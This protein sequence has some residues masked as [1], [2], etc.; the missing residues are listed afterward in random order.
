MHILRTSGYDGEIIAVN[1]RTPH[2]EGASSA[3]TL[4]DARPGPIDH[5]LVLTPATT[6]SD[7]VRACVDRQVGAVTLLSS[8]VGEPVHTDPAVHLKNLIGD[9][10]LRVL[11]PN[12]LGVLN[13]HT[14]LVASPA[15]AFMSGPLHAGGISIVSQSGAVGAYLVGLLA[16]VN[17][18]V[19]YFAS[20]GNEF[21]IQLG[22]VVRHFT[23]DDHTHSIALYLEGLRDVGTFIDS[24]A[25]AR[26]R[27]KDVIVIKAGGTETGAAAVRSHTAAMAGDDA[28][29]DAVFQRL[30]AYRVRSVGE[31]VEVLRACANRPP[32]GDR[33]RR[34]GVM[35]TSGG[36]G[37]LATEAL[38]HEGFEIPEV[39]PATQDHLRSVLPMCT[40]GRPIDLGGTVPRDPAEFLDLLQRTVDD[41]ALDSLVVVVSNMP[42]SPLAWSAIRATLVDLIGSRPVPI[43]VVGAVSDADS[44]M[45]RGLG[46][47]TASDPAAAAGEL[48]VLDRLATLR[49]S[50]GTVAHPPTPTPASR[51]VA[52]A[53]L[54]AMEMLSEHGIRF[55]EQV[56]LDPVPGHAPS[57]LG[58]I[59]LPAAVKLLQPGVLHKAA[60]GNVVTGVRDRAEIDALVRDFRGKAEGDGHILVQAMVDHVL[61]EVIVSIR[62]D[63]TFGPV[64]M[65]GSGGRHVELLKDRVLLLQPI[66]SDDVAGALA[67]LTFLGDLGHI[68]DRVNRKITEVVLAIQAVLD[69]EPR[70]QEVEINPVILRSEAPMAVAVDA[71]V[72]IAERAENPADENVSTCTPA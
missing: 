17:L 55:P 28:T 31:A 38:I 69:H 37:I 6:V 47:V 71:V 1:P 67:R 24:L 15:S 34:V 61:D 26:R 11:G 30:G 21:D 29:Y 41:L 51:V 14:R 43:V 5:A 2:F 25:E 8:G 58:K 70:V 65:I 42:R 45:F 4:A 64:V 63:P 62:R 66:S 18:G 56:V 39:P 23:N 48:T 44:A 7:V 46:A 68:A 33:I 32:G 10:G 35:T 60:A 52:M 22:E 36:L 9:S 16:Q 72:L 57:G 12:C 27:G 50:S 54:A 13:A 3:A 49:A 53:D 20:T 19:R 59:A 40:P